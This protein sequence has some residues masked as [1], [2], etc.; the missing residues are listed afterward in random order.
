MKTSIKD[1]NQDLEDLQRYIEELIVFLPLPFCI[2]NPLDII[3]GVNQAF[4]EL[5][6]YGEMEI[7]GNSI[8]FLFFEKK[9]IEIFKQE[10][11]K[12]KKRVDREMTLLTK[13]GKRIPVGLAASARRDEKGNFLGYFLTLSDISESKEFQEKLEQ[14]VIQRTKELQEKVEDLKRFN[15]LVIGREI[16]MIELKKELE[17]CREGKKVSGTFSDS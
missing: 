8:D 11:Q 7:M 6:E 15:K 5:T 1:L 9:E 17:E 13:D 3:L 10:I 14:E 4:Q 2:V 12:E 16:K